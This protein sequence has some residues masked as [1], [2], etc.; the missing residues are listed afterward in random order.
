MK[1]TVYAA[2]CGCG[3]TFICQKKDIKAVEVNN[4]PYLYIS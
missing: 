2:F 1:T 3:K 4:N